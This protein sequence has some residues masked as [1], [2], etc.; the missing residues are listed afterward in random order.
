MLTYD[1]LSTLTA[2]VKA[3][4]N[5]R[6]LFAQSAEAR[7]LTAI[8]PAHYLIGSTLITPL[9]PYDCTETQI[10]PLSRWL[11]I[12]HLRKQFWRRCSREYL[13]TSQ[14]HVKWNNEIE[15]LSVG[16]LVLLTNS[17]MY[18]GIARQIG[19]RLQGLSHQVST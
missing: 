11:Q 7:D 10:T 2:E 18:T 3:C 8:T 9:E 6:P 19:I 17:S 1:E 14:Q 16:D 5:S 15:N 4:L 12:F 13:R